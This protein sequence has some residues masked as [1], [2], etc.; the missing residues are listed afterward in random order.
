MKREHH[1]V[2]RADEKSASSI[3]QFCQSN[4]QILLPLVEKIQSASEMVNSVI[5][6]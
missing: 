5:H 4:G 2:S 6:A 3:G 1:I